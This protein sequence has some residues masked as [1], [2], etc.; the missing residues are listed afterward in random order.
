MSGY[1]SN[2]IANLKGNLNERYRDG[3]AI[4][5]EMIQNADDAGATELTVTFVSQLEGLQHPLLQGPLVFIA[6]NRP[7][8]FRNAQAIRQERGGSGGGDESKIGRFGLGLKSI[9]HLCEAFFYLSDPDGDALE[10][11]PEL[12]DYRRSDFMNPWHGKRYWPWDESWNRAA[13]SEIAKL[14]K[15]SQLFLRKAA[16]NWFSLVIPL[17]LRRHC[18]DKPTDNPD[19]FALVKDGYFDD[20][21]T[22]PPE[23][24]F[25]REQLEGLIRTMPLLT[26]LTHIE[27]R[28]ARSA[29]DIQ[30]VAQLHCDPT[31]GENINWRTMGIGRV[32]H[33]GFVT[34]TLNREIQSQKYCG[35][36]QL[37][38]NDALSTISSDKDW[39]VVE[40]LTDDGF[41]PVSA[42]AKQHVG[43]VLLDS[44]TPKSVSVTETLFLPLGGLPARTRDEGRFEL[45]LHGYYFVDSGRNGVDKPDDQ[46]NFSALQRASHTTQG[47]R[48]TETIR[49][50]WNRR[51]TE[52][53]VLPLIIPALELYAEKIADEEGAFERI[54]VLTGLLMQRKDMIAGLPHVCRDYE[55]FALLVKGRFQWLGTETKKQMPL[56]ALPVTEVW[57]LPLAVFPALARWACRA[58]ITIA[59]LSRLSTQTPA[60][61]AGFIADL[62]QS[63]KIEDVH[64]DPTQWSYF[65][66]C[67]ES[68]TPHFS[69]TE[70]SPLV[71]L[72]KKYFGST[73][74]NCEAQA[75]HLLSI[76]PDELV[77]PVSMI[78]PLSKTDDTL[79][80]VVWAAD[81]AIIALPQTLIGQ[82]KSG[83]LNANSALDLIQYVL[84][85][86]K[87]LRSEA[88]ELSVEGVSDSDD[89]SRAVASLI[90]DLLESTEAGLTTESE[91]LAN[92]SMWYATSGAKNEWFSLKELRSHVAENRLFEINADPTVYL[93][94]LR[95]EAEQSPV[96]A[97][98]RTVGTLRRL[99]LITGIS[100]LDET[101]F[102]QFLAG[103]PLLSGDT[104]ARAGCALHVARISK[105]QRLSEPHKAAIRY[106]LHGSPLDCDIGVPL[107]LDKSDAWSAFASAV[108]SA[109][110]QSWRLVSPSIVE[111]EQSICRELQICECTPETAISLL[112]SIADV[113]KIDFQALVSK[114]EQLNQVFF[115]WPKEKFPAL[116]SLKLFRRCSDRE[117][118]DVVREV[119]IQGTLPEEVAG[120]FGDYTFI[121]DDTNLL[122]FRGI[123]PTVKPVD[124]LKEALSREAV[125]QYWVFICNTLQLN[126]IDEPTREKLKVARWLPLVGG[127]GV[128]PENC[129]CTDGLEPLVRRL[130]DRKAKIAHKDQL[131]PA[132][133]GSQVWAEKVRNLCPVGVGILDVIGR[134]L[135]NLGGYEIGEA[136][137]SHVSVGEFL[138]VFAIAPKELMPVAEVVDSL[139]KNLTLQNL[140]DAIRDRVL[141][142][143]QTRLHEDRYVGV[144]TYLC[145]LPDVVADEGA[146]D[147]LFDS[148]LKEAVQSPSAESLLSQ[149]KLRN[150][151][152]N[153]VA[154]DQLTVY[155]TNVDAKHLLDSAQA[156]IVSELLRSLREA[157]IYCP[158]DGPWRSV[159]DEAEIK[160]S[161]G[162]L[163]D[164]LKK[165]HT[166]D[167][168]SNALAALV[169]VLGNRDG[170]PELYCRLKPEPS[171][172]EDMWSLLNISLALQRS[173]NQFCIRVA[174]ST[175]IPVTSVTGHEFLAEVSDVPESFFDAMRG[176]PDSDQGSGGSTIFQLR[177]R[178]CDVQKLNT[179]QKL[180]VLRHSIEDIRRFIW[181]CQS[182]FDAIWQK[183]I[184]ED[185]LELSV[186]QRQIL[187]ACSVILESQLAVDRDSGGLLKDLSELLLQHYA[188]QT[189]LLRAASDKSSLRRDAAA[190]TRRNTTRQIRKLLVSDSN[191]QRGVM[192]EIKDR[193]A[194]QNYEVASVPFEIFQNADDAVAELRAHCSAEFLDNIRPKEL[195]HTFRVE[196]GTDGSR[197]AFY[198]WGRAINQY[199]FGDTSVSRFQRDLE[200]ML[201]LQGSGKVHESGVT[202]H[203]GLGFKSVFFVT[204]E[205]RVFSGGKSRFVVKSGIYPE[206]LGD[207]D[208]DRL[209]CILQVLESREVPTGTVIEL[210]LRI[211]QASYDILSRFRQYAGYLVLFSRQIRR[212]DFSGESPVV[213]ERTE[214]SLVPQISLV[215]GIRPNGQRAIIFRL[216]NSSEQ[217]IAGAKAE[218]GGRAAILLHI[219]ANGLPALPLSDSIADPPQFPEVWVTT[220]ATEHRGTGAIVLNA[221]LDVNPGRTR[222]RDTDRNAMRLEQIGIM[223]GEVL[224]QFYTETQARWSEISIKLNPS[225]AGVS[226]R[227]FWEAFWNVC[228]PIAKR[229][230]TDPIRCILFGEK[231]GLSWLMQEKPVIPTSLP[232]PFD[233]PVRLHDIKYKCAGLLASL[234]RWDLLCAM[235]LRKK[236]AIQWLATVLQTGSVVSSQTYTELEQ[237]G[238][239]KPISVATALGMADVVEKLQSNAGAIVPALASALGR[240]VDESLVPTRDGSSDQSKTRIILQSLYFWT[241]GPSAT[242]V[243]ASRALAAAASSEERL[244]AALSP[245]EFVLSI[246]Y[247]ESAVKFLM[248]C[249][250]PL[251]L[252]IGELATWCFIAHSDKR[253]AVVHYLARGIHALSLRRYFED[254]RDDLQ[255]SWLAD[256]EQLTQAMLSLQESDRRMC[257]AVLNRRPV[258]NDYTSPSQNIPKNQS[259][260]VFKAIAVWWKTN[261]DALVKE[262]DRRVYPAGSMPE[263][264][265]DATPA[266]LRNDRRIR[267][268]WLTLMI[269]GQLF[270]LGYRDVQHR[271]FLNEFLESQIWSLMLD[272][273]DEP[274]AWFEAFDH[275]L[276]RSPENQSYFHWMNQIL[277]Y[278]QLARWLPPYVIAYQGITRPEA[279]LDDLGTIDDIA[280][281][282]SSHIFGR[283][284]GLDAPPCRKTLGLGAH[285]VLREVL[286][287]RRAQTKD[288]VAQRTLAAMSFVPSAG[289]RNLFRVITGNPTFDARTN[290]DG[291]AKAMFESAAKYVEDP[292]FDHCFDIPFRMLMW[293]KYAGKREEILGGV[294]FAN[295]DP[296]EDGIDATDEEGLAQCK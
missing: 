147:A 184:A 3:Y 34:L 29:D 194:S 96:L 156:R 6:N 258:E 259:E 238:V 152:G 267:C 212:I 98:K 104:V 264:K 193:L 69:A 144:L 245:C 200:K 81:S 48:R 216:G 19:R 1:H 32:R 97:A 94:C 143:L 31:E 42:E 178:P 106:L 105:S 256:D 47:D 269:R 114:S 118:V 288:Y 130:H 163:W 272:G 276:D 246:A 242:L 285:F 244:L 162:T 145:N 233:R 110:Q 181:K 76:I 183:L 215:S 44:P 209:R 129:V 26:T 12:R 134:E 160:A 188:A 101:G 88:D 241:D 196:S 270:R 63:V 22:V 86:G 189:E 154:T 236:P 211:E 260:A 213:V 4:L 146:K 92:L 262:H 66:Q 249:R 95:N 138:S 140:D 170:F 89:D 133:I 234:E 40:E 223:F 136:L 37:L 128:S 261:R 18:V 253:H 8:T 83:K 192:K 201:V 292:S 10:C 74:F 219:D 73:E 91:K 295:S 99:R 55:W 41:A 13:D 165:W 157:E 281:L 239:D 214:R 131:T 108:L 139:E 293:K 218:T 85:C 39:P 231:R 100:S 67:L 151:R 115:D 247:D 70:N 93:K 87:S 263:I 226:A 20:H 190:K 229:Q 141:K 132:L 227:Q 65:T 210:P 30:V 23:K 149:I 265:I 174:D 80:R 179:E 274:V 240:I 61:P 283:S 280:N 202:G 282:R 266:D 284:T 120:L 176:M 228:R 207:K 205:P 82:R 224:C 153:Y 113:H 72:V 237:T 268:E 24:I 161:P 122:A 25:G 142:P 248:F 49:Q 221:D 50:R 275:H 9:Y 54:E 273:L 168:P 191:T 175:K 199:R 287:S 60:L 59:E 125:H 28:H 250:G 230:T 7:F 127:T 35:Y 53:G 62:L 203:F 109:K 206:K 185:Q 173:A 79:L 257:C 52:V 123:V 155:A 232:A 177:I 135:T 15:H 197:V 225:D 278:Y 36:H 148:Y 150:R 137:F 14:R 289:V 187:G 46:G 159:P 294:Q 255:R 75:K 103:K 119:F 43:V 180:D 290:S 251:N 296:D 90:L 182:P 33:S 51:L 121:S 243:K 167:I 277:A 252:A 158:P 222:L 116:R 56:I 169:A 102:V 17:R 45:L 16:M 279:N 71:S 220:P 111:F 84:E 166:E 11:P 126:A 204:D 21:L 217:L 57:D 208:E 171:K 5:K 78:I 58:N 38:D 112:D 254:H 286:R 195:L 198:H 77:L 291:C 235:V 68:W 2:I 64:Q 271:R 124:L 107:L 117:L 164:Q 186:A 172:I 27:F